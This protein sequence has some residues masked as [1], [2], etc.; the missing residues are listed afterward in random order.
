MGSNWV[1]EGERSCGK[2]QHENVTAPERPTE[3]AC[4]G[5]LADN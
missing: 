1:N 3:A 5:R 2:S 4:G